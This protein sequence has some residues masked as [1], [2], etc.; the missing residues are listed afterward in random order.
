MTKSFSK[1]VTKC[2]ISNSKNL[3]SLLFL[4]YLPPVNTLQKIGSVPKEE[5]SFP[6]ELLYCN[7]SKLHEYSIAI[8]RNII[9][10]R[11]KSIA[12]DQTDMRVEIGH[13][14]SFRGHIWCRFPGILLV[15]STPFNL[16]SKCLDKANQKRHERYHTRHVLVAGVG[17]QIGMKVTLHW[18]WHPSNSVV[19]QSDIKQVQIIH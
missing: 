2:Q 16:D 10:S 17:Q 15:R 6:A 11:K 14:A 7:K 9:S 8:H 18:L 3:S 13:T 19:V 4:G 5:I 1:P 12:I